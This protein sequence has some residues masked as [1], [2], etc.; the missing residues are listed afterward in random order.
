[1]DK[2]SLSCKW[3]LHELENDSDYRLMP[4]DKNKGK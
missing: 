4:Y 1:M 3:I 2:G